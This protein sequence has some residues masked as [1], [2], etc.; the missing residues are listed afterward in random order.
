VNILSIS[1]ISFYFYV[2]KEE[3][4]A[5]SASTDV[6]LEF[7]GD[8]EV[9]LFWVTG[10]RDSAS[11]RSAVSTSVDEKLLFSRWLLLSADVVRSETGE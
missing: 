11:S 10:D 7:L 9:C 1:S 4:S 5:A 6:Q 2:Q 8:F 3:D